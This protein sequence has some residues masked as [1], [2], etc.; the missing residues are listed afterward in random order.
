MGIFNWLKFNKKV[1][2]KHTIDIGNTTHF[3]EFSYNT[4]NWTLPKPNF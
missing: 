1:D 4:P 3:D 2:F